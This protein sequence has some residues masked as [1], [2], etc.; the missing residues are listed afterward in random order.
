[1]TG[2]YISRQH[3]KKIKVLKA[4]S[5]LFFGFSQ[6]MPLTEEG[7][8]GCIKRLSRTEELR[9]LAFLKL[10]CEKFFFGCDARK[11]WSESISEDAEMNYIGEQLKSAVL[12]FSDYFGNIPMDVFCSKCEAFG[13]MLSENLRKEN[14]K[15]E[16][17]RTLIL[18]S[19]VF[20]A[21]AVFLILI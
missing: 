3:G 16:K 18:S 17:S 19:G 4:L 13:E 10:F 7:I 5:D 2:F 1:M 9:E 11:V 12:S 6:F 21:A 20:G 8:A 15:W 14:E